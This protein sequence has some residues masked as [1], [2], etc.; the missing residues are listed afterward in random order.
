MNAHRFVVSTIVV[1][2]LTVIGAGAAWAEE[3]TQ[4]AAPAEGAHYPD[5]ADSPCGRAR[6]RLARAWH[7]NR[8]E[9]DRRGGVRNHSGKAGCRR[10][11]HPADC[12]P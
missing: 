4:A 3:G 5:R 10:D 6:N 1:L 8:P 9:Q 12:H 7:R 11:S 2:L